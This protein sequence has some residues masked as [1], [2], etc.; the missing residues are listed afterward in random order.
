[1]LSMGL[2]G[3][4]GLFL[5]LHFQLTFKPFK[6][7]L[8]NT[9]ERFLR[10]WNDHKLMNYRKEQFSKKTFFSRLRLLQVNDQNKQKI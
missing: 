5:I 7:K 9:V 2:N 8:T 6:T 10:N 1:M 3:E 4:L